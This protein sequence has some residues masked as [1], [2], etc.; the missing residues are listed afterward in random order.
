M[1]YVR[2]V[3]ANNH[4]IDNMQNT[5]QGVPEVQ[6]L[7]TVNTYSTCS[8]AESGSSALDPSDE[9]FL[10]DEGMDISFDSFSETATPVEDCVSDGGPLCL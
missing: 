4:R 2:N 8:E 7:S 3:L 6:Q 5:T 9:S 1:E 10:L